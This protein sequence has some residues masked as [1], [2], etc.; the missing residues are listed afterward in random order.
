MTEK[1]LKAR[2]CLFH[3]LGA[4]QASA[5]KLLCGNH[6]GVSSMHLKNLCM[7]QE[8]Q[9]TAA[10]P[11][12]PAARTKWRKP[13]LTPE[14]RADAARHEAME[15]ELAQRVKVKTASLV[16]LYGTKVSRPSPFAR[17]TCHDWSDH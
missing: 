17:G 16:R 5:N 9:A 7:L 15:R 2:D 8:A 1:S 3:D 14:E 4:L 12:S 11:S 6:N 10:S 13:V